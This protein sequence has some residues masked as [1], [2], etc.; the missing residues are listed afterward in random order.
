MYKF[1]LVAVVTT[2]ILNAETITYTYY[3]F[4]ARGSNTVSTVKVEIP[5]SVN[6]TTATNELQK[7]ITETSISNLNGLSD[8]SKKKNTDFKYITRDN[9]SSKLS[10]IDMT[11]RYSG[12]GANSTI[13]T[14]YASGFSRTYRSDTGEFNYNF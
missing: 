11:P 3:C 1:I 4:P 7:S 14:H 8:L 2:T 6:F 12:G 9:V 13:T 5:T 10:K